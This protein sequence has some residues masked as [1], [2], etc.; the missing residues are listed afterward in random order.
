MGHASAVITLDKY[1][2]LFD[3]DLN[4]LRIPP[5]NRLE[6]LQGDRQDQHSIRYKDEWRV[7]FTWTSAGPA[8]VEITAHQ[9]KR[10]NQ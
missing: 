1:A 4:D 3:E 8:D 7:C 6:Q 5:G 2:D 9:W 10:R